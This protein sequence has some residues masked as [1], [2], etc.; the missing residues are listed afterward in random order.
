MRRKII[1][2]FIKVTQGGVARWLRNIT[3]S[4]IDGLFTD[5][6]ETCVAIII[7]GKRGITLIHDTRRLLIDRVMQEFKLIGEIAFWTTAYNP[8][9]QNTNNP[10]LIDTEIL[11]PYTD[12]LEKLGISKNKYMPPLGEDE[13]IELSSNGIKKY[14]KAGSYKC[15]SGFIAIN[16][17]AQIEITKKPASFLF[18]VST[19]QR[20]YIYYLNDLFAADGIKMPPDIIYDGKAFTPLP[21]LDKQPDEM[22]SLL[23]TGI[24]SNSRYQYFFITLALYVKWYLQKEWEQLSSRF[25]KVTPRKVLNKKLLTF[26]EE[27]FELFTYFGTLDYECAIRKAAAYGTSDQLYTLLGFSEYSFRHSSGDI[28]L[29]QSPSGKTPLHFAL[30]KK[31]ND[32]AFF[33]LDTGEINFDAMDENGKKPRDYVTETTSENVKM[34]FG[35]LEQNCSPSLTGSARSFGFFT[36][37]RSLSSLI[38]E[39]IVADVNNGEFGLLPPNERV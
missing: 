11:I 9:Y 10:D 18:P 29:V 39:P 21:S 30:E 25:S 14:Y 32:T 36:G 4:D 24:F 35:K 12:A 20:F 16:T 31:N 13:T 23:E 8:T 22:F 26:V 34:L 17:K 2:K 33:L 7:A 28:R 5:N 27:Y 15:V 6:L 38:S 19:Y 3:P 37:L 1:G